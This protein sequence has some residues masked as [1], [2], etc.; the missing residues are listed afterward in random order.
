MIGLPPNR[1]TA[2]Y[3]THRGRKPKIAPEEILINLAIPYNVSLLSTAFTF[4]ST[5]ESP[6]RRAA[7]RIPG[8]ISINTS[9]KAFSAF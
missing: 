9:D 3:A 2:L 8:I 4:P 1:L 6:V 7:A 5:L